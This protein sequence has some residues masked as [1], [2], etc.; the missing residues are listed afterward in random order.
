MHVRRLMRPIAIAAISAVTIL[1][2]VAASGAPGATA[3][4][5]SVL[6][7]TPLIVSTTGSTNSLLYGPDWAGYVATGSTSSASF[8]T[9]RTTF[10]VPSL[11]CTQTP[12]GYVSHWAGLDGLGY[13]A[14]SSSSVEAA[15][16]TAECVGGVASYNAW[17][18]TYPDPQTSVFSVNAGDTI[19]V[20][21][22]YSGADKYNF[23]VNDE[24]TGQGVDLMESC[25]AAACRNSSAEV[26]TSV[27]SDA[28][29]VSQSN[30]LTLADYGTAN[31]EQIGVTNA[32]DQAGGFSSTTWVDHE[33]LLV[34]P[35][36]LAP[37]AGTGT[38]YAGEAFFTSYAPPGVVSP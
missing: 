27:P 20:S 5:S 31:F 1:A 37:L 14:S 19:A 2:C 16:A 10:T 23:I 36:T 22:L 38:L 26:V 4:S 24:T 34:N 9:A 3:A 21:V 32:A 25:A 33:A 15:G 29:G 6:Y 18:E 30:I 12:N 35:S 17:W 7:T 11:N 13:N 28:V 8:V